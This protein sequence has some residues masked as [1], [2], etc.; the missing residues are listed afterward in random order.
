MYVAV[1]VHNYTFDLHS[2]PLHTYMY[3]LVAYCHLK[4]GACGSSRGDRVR[5]AL[6][7]DLCSCTRWYTAIAPYFLF[8]VRGPSS[9]RV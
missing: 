4:S 3:V 7:S 1:V 5:G 8:P 2:I 6:L 9:T